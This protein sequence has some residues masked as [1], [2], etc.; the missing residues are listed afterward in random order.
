MWGSDMRRN[1]RRW[2][3]PVPAFLCCVLVLS[4][5]S[6]ALGQDAA[7][8]VYDSLFNQFAGQLE[9]MNLSG[10]YTFQVNVAWWTVTVCDS[11][12]TAQVSQLNFAT[13]PG[14]TQITGSVD[15][16]WCGVSFHAPL[17]T[18]ANASY[19]NGNIW[20]S[21]NPTYIQPVVHI[22][23]WD[24]ALPV[25]IDVSSAL[26]LPPIPINTALFGFNTAQGFETL[27]LTP[28]N[29]SL[30]RGNGYMELD[31]DLSIW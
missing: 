4:S 9:P 1:I 13:S 16:S 10:H 28:L 15:A 14:G 27:R 20:I 19:S 5:P 11:D 29:V 7:V 22:L 2:L 31:S 26:T 8:R 12:W 21:A 18:S 6:V 3:K 30:T 25:S 23:A 17:N 24:V